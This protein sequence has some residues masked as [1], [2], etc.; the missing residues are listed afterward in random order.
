MR[1]KCIR[2]GKEIRECMGFVLARDLLKLDDYDPQLREICE[3]CT[4]VISKRQNEV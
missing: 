2:C 4:W 1:R 3:N